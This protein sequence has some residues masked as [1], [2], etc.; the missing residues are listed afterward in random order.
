MNDVVEQIL[1]T[2]TVFKSDDWDRR[3]AAAEYAINNPVNISTDIRRFISTMATIQIPFWTS[4][5][6]LKKKEFSL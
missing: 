3:L 1:R 2:Y 6:E 5:P 4:L